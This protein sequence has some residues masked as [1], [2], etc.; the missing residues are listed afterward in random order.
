LAKISKSIKK[1]LKAS[2]TGSR[3]ESG[4]GL[5]RMT[6]SYKPGDLVRLKT[7]EKWGVV[8]ETIHNG[9]YVW[10]L[11]AGGKERLRSADLEK[12]QEGKHSESSE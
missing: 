10:V 3:S 8:V 1:K 11:T 12:I 7:G 4:I 9:V 2:Y 6:W 5:S